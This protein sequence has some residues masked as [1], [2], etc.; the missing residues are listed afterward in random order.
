MG[1]FE[2]QR[3][4]GTENT[5][6]GDRGREDGERKGRERGDG[7]REGREREG[8]MGMGIKKAPFGGKGAFIVFKCWPSDC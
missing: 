6:R 2:T 7:E 4:R 3:H 8:R 1:V 5:G